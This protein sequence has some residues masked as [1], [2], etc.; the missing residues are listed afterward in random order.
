M[1]RGRVVATTA[2]SPRTAFHD[3]PVKKCTSSIS[4]KVGITPKRWAFLSTLDI[5]G[6]ES[7]KVKGFPQGHTGGLNVGIGRVGVEVVGKTEPSL[8]DPQSPSSESVSLPIFHLKGEVLI[9][10]AYSCYLWG[11][12]C[13]SNVVIYTTSLEL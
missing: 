9:L 7:L 4:F 2:N 13:F 3:V 10:H 12:L 1:H 6:D 11:A 8:S 5:G